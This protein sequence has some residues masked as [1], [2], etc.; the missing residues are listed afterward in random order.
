MKIKL[1]TR[2]KD[3]RNQIALQRAYAHALVNENYQVKEL[4][5][6]VAGLF[7]PCEKDLFLH[8]KEDVV[9]I[10]RRYISRKELITQEGFSEFEAEVFID[11]VSEMAELREE[12][13]AQD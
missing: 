7:E 13:R 9:V 1:W 10:G 12:L 4:L 5:C 8:K 11:A 3:L 2:K 6:K